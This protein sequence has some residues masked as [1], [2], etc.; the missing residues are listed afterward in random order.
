MKRY[1]FKLQWWD[2][3]GGTYIRS[4]DTW[5]ERDRFRKMVERHDWRGHSNVTVWENIIEEVA[6]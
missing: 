5:E 3:Q 1:S 2:G 6:Q 4:F